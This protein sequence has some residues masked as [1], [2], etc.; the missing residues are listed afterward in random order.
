V[1]GQ[2]IRKGII[3]TIKSPLGFFVLSLLI[4][5]AFIT[6]VL[7]FS[8]LEPYYKFIGFIIGVSLFVGIVVI[9]AIFAWFKPH[10]LTYSEYAHLINSGKIPYGTNLEEVSYTELNKSKLTEE[11]R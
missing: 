4:V 3:E 11:K 7:V 6:I 8:N 5:E 1:K 9:V 10:N 2:R